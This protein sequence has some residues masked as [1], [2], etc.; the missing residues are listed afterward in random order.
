VTSVLVDRAA[1]PSERLQGRFTAPALRPGL[2]AGLWSGLVALVVVVVAGLALGDERVPGYTVVFRLVGAAFV[3]CGLVAWRR[4]PDSY[5]GLL[6][7]ATGFLLFVE[8]VFAQFDSGS[9]DVAG[10]V[11]GDLWSIPI[12]WLLLTMLSGG[13]LATRTD[14][15][16]VSVFVVEF[17]LSLGTVLFLEHDG[18]FLLVHSDEAIADGFETARALLVSVALIA[19]AVVIGARWRA[20]SRPRRRAMLPGVGGLGALLLFAVAQQTAPIWLRWAAVLSLL[21]IPAGFLAGLLSSRLARGGLADLFR[22]LPTMRSEELQPALARALGD[23]TVEVARGRP[24]PAPGRSVAQINEDAALVYDASLDEDP[25]LI[26]AVASAAGIA[27]ESRAR[28]ERIVTAGDDERRRLERNLHDGAQQRL[29]AL[30]MQLRLI[31]HEL[32]SDPAAAEQL[33]TNASEELALSLAELRELAR[34]IH[35]AV[36][37]HGLEPA[38]QTLAGQATVPTEVAY[39]AE[40]KLPEPVEL[41]AYFVTSEALANVGKYARARSA[42]VRVAR[43]GGG[44]VVE[45][46]DDGVGGADAARGSGL[47]GLADRVEALDGRLRVDSPPGAGTVVRAELPCAS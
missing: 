44:L 2:A 4:R 32:H 5:S 26:E 21:A 1:P 25:E 36:L 24:Q 23:P 40:G 41:A 14:R 17:F 34:G 8:P 43:E 47:R 28:L 22:R 46:A 18:N 33:V 38:L 9:A 31:Q 10:Y 12:V 15:V 37:D 13:R 19:I 11:F 30:A 42:R 29:V 6:M 45:I 20:A 16:L 27:L 3:A 39:A 35:P 7:T